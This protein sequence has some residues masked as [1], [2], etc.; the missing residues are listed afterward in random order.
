M[1][2]AR[3]ANL[4]SLEYP[5]DRLELIVACDGSTDATPE[6][7]RAAGADVVLELPR[8]GKILAQDAGVEHARGRDRR[9]LGRQ[10]H[11][12]AR[13]AREPDRAVR[14]SERR[15]RVRRRAPGRRERHQPGGALLAL[16]DGAA[17]ARVTGALGDRRQR[18]D[19]RHASRR[20]RGRRPDH[21][22]RPLVPV[23]DGQARLAGGVRARRQRQREDG[24]D[25]GG[26]VRAQ[27]ADDGPH[28]A[29][30]RPRRDALSA[31]LRPAVRADDRLA[32]G[33]ALRVAV[34]ARDRAGRRTSRCS[35]TAGSTSARW[36]SSS[37]CC[38]RR[39]PP[40]RSPPA[41]S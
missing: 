13:R 18:R 38:S 23:H 1:I 12:G 4:R 17:G 37:G 15:L 14:R 6:R 33:A 11:L 3:I 34:P 28:L 35:A 20:L 31:R 8:G 21:G 24:A 2:A 9:V 16:R 22:P 25:A 30:R 41:R 5:A 26:R 19:L 10:R 40:P 29:D 36:R 39:S 7:A 27:A 32:P